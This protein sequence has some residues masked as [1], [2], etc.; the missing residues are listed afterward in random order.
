MHEKHKENFLFISHRHCT[1]TVS[2]QGVQLLSWK[3]TNSEDILWSSTLDNFKEGYAF[4]GGIPICWP[5]FG[6]VHTPSHGFARLLKW[7]LT[8]HVETQE[9]VTLL[10]TLQESAYTLKL[11]PYAFTLT[12]TMV[13]GKRLNVSL[14]VVCDV[15]TTG[16]LHSYFRTQDAREEKIRGLGEVYLDALDAHKEKHTPYPLQF[17]QEVDRVYTQS[18]TTTQITSKRRKLTLKHSGYSDIVV[19]NPWHETSSKLADMKEDDYLKM[20]CV[21]SAKIST[22]FLRKDVLSLCLFY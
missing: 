5:W 4:R 2:L 15:K 16:A 1:A 10:F 17:T 7:H 11:F 13:L 14:E 22:S 8:K 9:H 20:F 18:D 6:K 12:L 19:W 3:P 21:E